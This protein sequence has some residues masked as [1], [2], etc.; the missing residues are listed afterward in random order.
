MIPRSQ[1]SLAE[2]S[3]SRNFQ[4]LN[5]FKSWNLSRYSARRSSCA[6]T[7]RWWREL[8]LVGNQELFHFGDFQFLSG[9]YGCA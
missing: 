1:V 5:D 6:S 3:E 8:K 4:R 9:Y 2:C 7:A